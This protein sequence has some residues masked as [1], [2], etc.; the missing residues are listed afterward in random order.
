[1]ERSLSQRTAYTPQLGLQVSK[2]AGE[3]DNLSRGIKTDLI[4]TREVISLLNETYQ[5]WIS[6]KSVVELDFSSVWN[7]AISTRLIPKIYGIEKTMTYGKE[8]VGA[9][10]YFI[11][12]Q[13]E[14]L[15]NASGARAE[16]A[17]HVMCEL[18]Q[19]LLAE[20]NVWWR[21]GGRRALAA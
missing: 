1:M 14:N 8:H 15:N 5:D 16:F 4:Q 17:R 11:L 18:G 19:S 13:L 21:Q 7:S 2:A 10:L 9:G 3:L 6:R 12:E 20:R